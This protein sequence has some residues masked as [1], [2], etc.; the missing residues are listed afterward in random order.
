M[1][2]PVSVVA[3]VVTTVLLP[4]ALE[5]VGEKI[6]ETTWDKSTEAIQIVRETVQAKLQTAGTAGLLT[7]VEANPNEANTQVLQA[8]IVTQMQEDQDFATKLQELVKKMQSQS[9]S[10]QVILEELRVRGKV[11]IG[12]IKQVNEG[13]SNAKQTFGKNWQVGGDVK[14]GDVTQENRSV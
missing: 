2:D 4:K 7:R 10:V 8:E 1:I 12:N 6:G 9:P 3:G 13:Q 5:K 14:V 11:E